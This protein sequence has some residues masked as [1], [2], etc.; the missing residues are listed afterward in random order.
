MVIGSAAALALLYGDAC[1][2]DKPRPRHAIAM[3]G[4]PAQPEGFTHFRY[5]NPDAPIASTPTS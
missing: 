3:H 2:Q 4:E 1:A 5:A